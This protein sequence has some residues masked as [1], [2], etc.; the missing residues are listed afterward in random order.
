[1]PHSSVN[2]RSER[3]LHVQ[4]TDEAFQIDV[5]HP[6]AYGYTGDR[7]AAHLTRVENGF[8]SE[9]NKHASF[10]RYAH[11]FTVSGSA[12]ADARSISTNVYAVNF[13]D[14]SLTDQLV[15]RP[16]SARRRSSKRGSRATCGFS[17]GPELCSRGKRQPAFGEHSCPAERSARLEPAPQR[18]SRRHAPYSAPGPRCCCSASASPLALHELA[19]PSLSPRNALPAFARRASGNDSAAWP[20]YAGPFGSTRR[21]RYDAWPAGTQHRARRH[22]AHAAQS[23]S[24]GGYFSEAARNGRHKTGA[25]TGILARASVHPTRAVLLRPLRAL[26]GTRAAPGTLVRGGAAVC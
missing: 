13:S 23:A 20:T 8:S 22:G 16:N 3:L 1:M 15:Y 21:A 5:C 14:G 10:S 25:C 26:A 18:S 7:A 24:R 2:V 17:S 6:S 4:V 9:L 19:R 12:Y 11:N